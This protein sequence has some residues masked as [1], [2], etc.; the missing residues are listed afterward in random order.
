MRLISQK[1]VKTR[2]PHRCCLCAET[3]EPGETADA[4]AVDNDGDL[5]TAYSHLECGRAMDEANLWDI[6]G[7]ALADTLI[8]NHDYAPNWWRKWFSGKFPER[9]KNWRLSD[10]P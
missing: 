7:G 2:K 4:Q 3:I 10:D 5:G 8:E 1:I 6:D 9:T